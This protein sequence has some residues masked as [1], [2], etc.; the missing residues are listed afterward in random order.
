MLYTP[1][2]CCSIFSKYAFDYTIGP[3]V[4]IRKIARPRPGDCDQ[5][6]GSRS[7]HYER[8]TAPR[9]HKHTQSKISS[10][11]C[12]NPCHSCNRLHTWGDG[13]ALTKRHHSIVLDNLRQCW[14][15]VVGHK[16]HRR[17][18]S[19]SAQLNLKLN[20]KGP[21]GDFESSQQGPGLCVGEQDVRLLC[22]LCPLNKSS[23][24][25]SRVCTS[26][27]VGVSVGVWQRRAKSTKPLG[28]TAAE[29]RREGQ[30]RQNLWW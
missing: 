11:S 23:V 13:S 16:L 24:K 26:E 2:S 9:R 7:T 15:D 21:H 27:S 1:V 20:V 30:S 19:I 14:R 5:S 18:N 29:Q 10:F 6:P 17:P 22:V 4:G 28:K 25:L 3:V 12:V 8:T